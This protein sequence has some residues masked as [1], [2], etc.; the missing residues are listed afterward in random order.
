MEISTQRS[1]NLL[2]ARKEK[3]V[4]V[5]AIGNGTAQDRDPVK[6]LWRIAFITK[7]K[8]AQDI[9]TDYHQHASSRVGADENKGC[10]ILRE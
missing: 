1:T 2:P 3:R 9:Q 8:L 10:H 6:D 7:E 4:R 5:H